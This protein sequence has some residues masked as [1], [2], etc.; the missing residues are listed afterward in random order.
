MPRLETGRLL[1]RPP[2]AG[3]VSS[4]TAWIGDYDVAKNLASAPHPYREDDAKAFI[5]RMAER[6]A[7]GEGYCFSIVRKADNVFMGNC[8]LN[9]SEG[10]CELGYWLGKPFWGQGYATEAARKVLSFAF[11]DLKA[12]SVWAGWFHDN[13]ASGR[14][15]EKLGARLDGFEPR[16][17]VARGHAVACHIVTLTR[18]QFG[19]KRA[20]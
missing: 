16:T 20:A 2:D 7:K 18:A 10:R 12:E 5:E 9:L 17:S 1:L 19:R 13:P 15:L 3:D 11:H 8:G 4:I 6:L 14:V